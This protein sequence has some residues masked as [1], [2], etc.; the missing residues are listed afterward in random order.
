MTMIQSIEFKNFRNVKGKYEFNNILNVIIGKNNSG[1]SNLLDGIKLAFS[2]ISSEFFKVVKSDFYNSDDSQPIEI[3]VELK[4]GAIPS[5]NYYIGNGVIKCGFKVLVRKTPG[6]RYVKDVFLSNG[7]NTDY[8]ILRDDPKIPNV[9]SIPLMRIEEIYSNG[10][11]TGI[12]NFIES[13]ERYRELKKDSKEKINQVIEEKVS[14]FKAFCK[15][16]NQNF[17]IEL[18]EPKITDERVYVVEEG[19]QEHHYKIGSGYKSIANIILNTFNNDFNIIL[20][21]EIENHLHPSLIRTLIRELKELKNAQ[22]IS[23]THSAVVANEL[24]LQE[25]IDIDYKNIKSS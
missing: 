5:L 2:A 25:I 13:E 10:F 22:I 14:K 12:S 23:T 16:F 1:K 3:T 4:P 19:H 6:G 8:D 21:D 18:T 11:V 24:D 20:I 17:D 7:C 15:K 9:F